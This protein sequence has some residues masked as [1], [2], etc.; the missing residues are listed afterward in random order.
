MPTQTI[1]ELVRAYLAHFVETNNTQACV[2]ALGRAHLAG[3][4]PALVRTAQLLSFL[5]KGHEGAFSQ[6][7]AAEALGVSRGHL[8][9]LL[10]DLAAR[11]A[12]RV[13][14]RS[15]RVA[16][17][18]TLKRIAA[19]RLGEKPLASHPEGPDGAA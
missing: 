3:G 8:N 10:A 18:P 11:G 19:G 6:L 2:A 7:E 4:V 9:L 1:E 13:T 15:I 12:L 16:S 14:R 17:Y 5:P